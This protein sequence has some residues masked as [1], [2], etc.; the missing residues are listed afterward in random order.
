MPTDVPIRCSCGAVR[1]IARGLEPSA[2]N[3]V[4]CY[5]DD[6]QAFAHFLGRAYEMLDANGGS[7]IFQTS[8]ARLEFTRGGDQLACMR[9]SESGLLRWHSGCCNT[10]I[11]NTLARPMAFV[12][13]LPTCMDHAASGRS[14]D[15]ALG[16]VRGRVQARHAYGDLGDHEAHPGFSLRM[17]APMLRLLVLGRL[18]GEHKRS[19]FVDASTGA[20]RVTPRVLTEAERG[21]IRQR[22]RILR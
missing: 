19:P 12:G 13:L 3:R 14:R 10:A 15:D 22:A 8:P 16:P 6:C 11:G 9:L 17:L 20:P 7:D 4:V 2:G 21:A 18:R 5:C 1:G